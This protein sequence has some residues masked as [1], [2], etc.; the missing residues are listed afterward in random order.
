MDMPSL[1][2]YPE[3]E[4]MPL[5]P[6][7]IFMGAENIKRSPLGGSG[8]GVSVGIHSIFMVFWTFSTKAVQTTAYEMENTMNKPQR[9]IH[10]LVA[11]APFTF[12]NVMAAQAISLEF[13]PVA[14]RRSIWA[15][16]PASMWS[17][18][19]PV[20]RWSAGMTFLWS[21]T[22]PSFPES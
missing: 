22:P 12:C 11:G 20:V 21:G 6:P 14:R 15:I 3:R 1:K 13:A 17:S 19:T 2:E 16:L 8:L 9:V 18:Q 5:T 10:L 7:L 4:K